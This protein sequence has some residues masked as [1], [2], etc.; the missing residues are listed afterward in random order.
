MTDILTYKSYMINMNGN[1]FR[2]KETK[3]WIKNLS[4]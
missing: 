2:L 1:S 3:K 4:S